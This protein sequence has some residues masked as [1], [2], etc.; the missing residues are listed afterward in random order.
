MN[1]EWWVLLFFLAVSQG[2]APE[3]PKFKTVT[4]MECRGCGRDYH[5]DP[6]N[7]PAY[8]SSC[9]GK[10]TET[11]YVVENPEHDTWE[12]MKELREKINEAKEV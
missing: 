1:G 5:G 6:Y 4:K 3:P 7:A 2:E 8:C 11:A 9:G 12:R 10:I